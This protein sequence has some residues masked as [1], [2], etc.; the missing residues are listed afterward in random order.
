MK[1]VKKTVE[2]LVGYEATDGTFFRN[3][4]ACAEYEKSARCA[5]NCAAAKLEKNSKALDQIMHHNMIGCWEER[6]VV[7]DIK[8]A[9][10]LQVV[11]THL[12]LVYPGGNAID[13]R[14][15]GQSVA[16]QYWVDDDGYNV[17]G[18]MDEILAEFRSNLDKLFSDPEVQE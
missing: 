11:N 12:N 9:D 10:Q 13:P 4:D 2:Q 18:N 16:V 15:I 7:Y 8:N 14:Y 5:A 3:Q 1:E 17:L 6:V